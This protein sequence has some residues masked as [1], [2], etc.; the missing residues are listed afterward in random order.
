MAKGKSKGNVANLKP[1]VKG[2]SGN[3]KGR[4]KRALKELQEKAGVDFQ[5]HLSRADKTRILES[6]ME[7]NLADLKSIA[8]DGR[9]PAF[10]VV[11]ANAI[12]TDVAKGKMDSLIMLMDRFYGRPVQAVAVMGA[13]VEAE[14]IPLEEWTDAEVVEELERLENSVSLKSQNGSE[15]SEEEEA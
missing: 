1:W 9:A 11:L 8:T 12:K 15:G 10:M 13:P 2:Q 5:V 7:M 14:S 6:M 4:P 3:P